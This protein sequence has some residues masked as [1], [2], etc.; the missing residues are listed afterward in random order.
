MARRT[1]ICAEQDCGEHTS[2][3]NHPLCRPHWVESQ[4]GVIDKCPNH[5]MV[6]KPSGFPVCR[7][8]RSQ[9]RSYTRTSNSSGVMRIQEDTR[10]WD[11]GPS[12]ARNVQPAVKAV[13]RVR[14]NLN[15]HFSEC[16]N[17]ETNTIQFLVEPVLRGLGWEID[18]PEQVFREYKPHIKNRVDIAL[19]EGGIPRVM[20][21]AKRLDR[22]YDPAYR[23]QIDRY[24]SFMDEGIAVLTNGRFWHI[25]LVHN[26]KADDR[27]TT[28][29]SQGNPEEV[30]KNLLSAIG[31]GVIRI[32]AGKPSELST[33]TD[34]L[35]SYRLKESK[36][37]N[38][39]AFTIF[40]DETIELI[41]SKKP[42]SIQELADIKGIGPMKLK[43]H[44]AEILAIVK[45]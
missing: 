20:V 23:Q 15:E 4:E 27:D 1:P 42:L 33:I 19:L 43:E 2:R 30:A 35:R 29:I 5:P 12:K 8:C 13:S 11:V 40:S 28:D 3:S 45:G 9:A 25:S 34:R 37:R 6:W 18:D 16:K 41:A 31:K 39:R 36:R 38:K 32:S 7:T 24:A 21:E 17:S 26:G 10:G 22:D 14:K 44:G